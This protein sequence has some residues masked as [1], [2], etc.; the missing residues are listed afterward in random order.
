MVIRKHITE[1]ENEKDTCI[2]SNEFDV[3]EF[4]LHPSIKQIMKIDESVKSFT[5]CYWWRY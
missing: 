5:R 3:Q 2:K 4:E 1:S